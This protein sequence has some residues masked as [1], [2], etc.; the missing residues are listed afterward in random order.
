MVDVVAFPFQRTYSWF[1]ALL[2]LV[3][4]WAPLGLMTKSLFVSRPSGLELRVW[5]QIQGEG[6]YGLS[7][8]VRHLLHQELIAYVHFSQRQS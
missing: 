6:G 3:W 4:F 1:R 2:G 7:E 8:M 5:G